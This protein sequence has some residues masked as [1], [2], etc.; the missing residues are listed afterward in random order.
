MRWRYSS[1]V[2]L[3]PLGSLWNSE[4]K[5]PHIVLCVDGYYI[6]TERCVYHVWGDCTKRVSLSSLSI[7]VCVELNVLGQ[8]GLDLLY[9]LGKN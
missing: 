9:Q 6:G 1:L 5:N 3:V 2:D 7:K 8:S 4:L